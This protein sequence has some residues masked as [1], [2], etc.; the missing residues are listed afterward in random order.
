MKPIQNE[1]E[2]TESARR[3]IAAAPELLS[4]LAEIVDHAQR[5]GAA[6]YTAVKMFDRARAA[7]ARAEGRAE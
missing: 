3:L 2:V 5:Y 1:E 4:A 7:I 6:P